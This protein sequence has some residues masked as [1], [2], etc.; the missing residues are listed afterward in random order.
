MGRNASG[1]IRTDL[2]IRN[3]AK[4]IVIGQAISDLADISAPEIY[5]LEA[6]NVIC[7]VHSIYKFFKDFKSFIITSKFFWRKYIKS[8][9]SK[10]KK[11]KANA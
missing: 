9:N 3:Q 7:E 6:G 1:T 10:I 4:D 2:V 8:D 5:D 11:E